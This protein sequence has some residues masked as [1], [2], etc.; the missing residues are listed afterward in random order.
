MRQP[1]P[2]TLLA[3]GLYAVLNAAWGDPLSVSD[4]QRE[5]SSKPPGDAGQGQKLYAQHGCGGCHSADGLASN[6][7]W[8]VMA[9]QRPIYIYKMLLDYQ[10]DR[11]GGTDAAVMSSV[12][13]G[14]NREE[15]ASIASWLGTLPRPVSATVNTIEPAVLNGDRTRLIPPCSACHGANGQ[16][17]DLQPALVGQNRPYLANALHRF[18]SGERGNDIN[19]GM[20]Q[21]AKKLTDEEIEAL[22]DYYGR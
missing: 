9:G 19:S 12:A 21:F 4:W 20:N 22:A 17:W 3:I 11:L 5:L 13:K 2:H 18:K 1:L 8:P 10:A 16:G 6:A 14:L 7:Q 15:M